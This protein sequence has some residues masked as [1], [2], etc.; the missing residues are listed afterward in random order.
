MIR[1]FA[2]ELRRYLFNKFFI[3]LLLVTSFFSVQIMGGEIILGV[4]GTAPFSPW[5]FGAYLAKILPFLLVALLFFLSFLTSEQEKRVHAL[6][7]VTPIHPYRFLFLRY[8]AIT[9]AF[10]LIALVPVGYA[11]WFYGF[12]FQ[13][14]VFGSLILPLFCT[15]LPAFLFIMGLGTFVGHF[16]PALL[17]GLMPAVLLV[18]LLPMSGPFDLYGTNLFMS[19]PLTLEELDPSFFLPAPVILWKVGYSLAGI[20]MGIFALRRSSRVSGGRLRY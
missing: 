19:Y 10:T 7:D 16:N 15:V 8:C 12:V 4:A 6:T 14:T 9:T 18:G 2:Y 13:Y 17:Y 1:L 20:I 11:C 5:S 3:G